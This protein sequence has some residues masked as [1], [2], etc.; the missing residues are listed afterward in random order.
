MADLHGGGRDQRWELS[1]GEGHDAGDDGCR[2]LESSEI[3]HCAWLGIRR[4]RIEPYIT[5][6]LFPES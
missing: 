6:R 2:F 1:R 5:Q 3:F 4:R